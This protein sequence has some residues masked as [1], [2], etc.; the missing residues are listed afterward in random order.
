MTPV[1]WNTGAFPVGSTLLER[2]E[3]LADE[4][5]GAVLLFTPDVRSERSGH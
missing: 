3:S 2:I 4:F 5:E 1:V